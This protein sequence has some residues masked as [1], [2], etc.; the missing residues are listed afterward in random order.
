MRTGIFFSVKPADMERLR[1]LMKDS[2][3][4]QKHV[5]RAQIVLLSAE[6]LG[7]NAI[8][9]TAGKSKT[10]SRGSTPSGRQRTGGY[11]SRWRA[12]RNSRGAFRSPRQFAIDSKSESERSNRFRSFVGRDGVLA[13]Q[14][15]SMDPD[16]DN[17]T[18]LHVLV[19][20]RVDRAKNMA[21]FY[22]LSIEPTLFEDLALVRRWGRI[23]SVGRER[24]D[25]HPSRSVAQIELKKWLDRKRR[26]GYHLRD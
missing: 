25:L 2:N 15:W 24:I 22:V 3:A 16:A 6:G 10:M 26:R 21:R 11:D 8:M 12:S 7:T 19:L 17:P 5:W 9:R 23:G 1:A 18:L 13:S 20:E 14:L 4:P